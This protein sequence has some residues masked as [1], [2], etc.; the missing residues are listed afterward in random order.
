MNVE[1]N[2]MDWEKIKRFRRLDTLRICFSTD[3]FFAKLRMKLEWIHILILYFRNQKCIPWHR[4]SFT[5]EFPS[6]QQI[7]VDVPMFDHDPG[8]DKVPSLRYLDLSDCWM[9]SV[10]PSILSLSHLQHLSLVGFRSKYMPDSIFDLLQLRVLDLSYSFIVS[11]PESL[12]RLKSLRRL[13]L[14]RCNDLYYI[15]PTIGDL[16][17]LEELNLRSTSI[18]YLPESIQNLSR[19]KN[20]NLRMNSDL[21]LIQPGVFSKMQ[22]LEKIKLHYSGNS[23]IISVLSKQTSLKKIEIYNYEGP[24]FC[25]EVLGNL[26]NLRILRLHSFNALE[27]PRGIGNLVLLK[28]LSLRNNRVLRS[29]PQTSENLKHLERLD[30]SGTLISC[31]PLGA[32]QV[33]S[34]KVLKMCACKTC[35]RRRIR[36]AMRPI[37][38]NWI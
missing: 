6:I 5:D 18:V 14:K 21:R 23:D 20:L 32:D 37:F 17:S 9:T 8:F 2:D 4:F 27:M 7:F 3:S 30:L 36:C 19:L 29:L 13:L 33:R 1:L 31:I 12:G 28:E 34:L 10:P 22:S 11:L 24:G 35:G 16:S 25:P 15:P 26:T 38:K